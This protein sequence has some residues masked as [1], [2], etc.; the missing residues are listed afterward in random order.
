MSA[1][2]FIEVTGDDVESAIAK[3]LEQLGVGPGDVMVEVIEEAS[4]GMFGIGARPARVRL[5]VIRMA[6]PPP[7]Q[8]PAPTPTPAPEP[9]RTET[10]PAKPRV[11]IDDYDEDD[12]NA[13]FSENYI[14]YAADEAI[15]EDAEVGK[16]VLTELLEK[17]SVRA[18]VRVRRA[19]AAADEEDNNPWVLDVG[20]RGD[21][22]QLI[23]RRGE[24]LAALQYITRL[25]TSREL[26]RR[27]N[28]VVDV[29]GYKSRRTSNLHDLAR[30][31][32]EQA[33]KQGRTV[34]LE[35]MPPYERRI[36]HLA[37]RD[38]ATVVTKSVGEGNAR[39]VTIV[40]K[41]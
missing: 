8:E 29:D 5:Q 35:P 32:A 41:S 14:E 31:M 16:V 26:Q 39:K 33:V 15:D 17:M 10:P 12:E 27:A 11:D 24:T 30:R 28:I 20:G 2:R 22:N 38:N 18:E 3:G 40:P 23:G 34:S 25:I 6:P 19:A 36:I 21:M 37:L 4:R 1:E 13:P 7:A 9:A